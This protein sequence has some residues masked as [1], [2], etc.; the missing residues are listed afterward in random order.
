MVDFGSFILTTGFRFGGHFRIAIRMVRLAPNDS[1]LFV[2]RDANTTAFAPHP[3][4]SAC[5][6]Q[7]LYCFHF[8]SQFHWEYPAVSENERRRQRCNPPGVCTSPSYR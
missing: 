4:F 1:A 3:E 2:W 6:F 5:A 8:S 7:Y